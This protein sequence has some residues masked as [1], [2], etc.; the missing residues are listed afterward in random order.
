M[1][2]MTPAKA[3]ITSEELGANWELECLF[4]P[5]QFTFAKAVNWTKRENKGRNIPVV[6]FSGGQPASLTMSLFFDVYEP[7]RTKSGATVTDVRKFTNELEKLTLIDTDNP[8]VKNKVTGQARPPYCMFEWG[9]QYKF[10]AV[11]TSLTVRYTLFRTNGEPVRAEAD[12][13]F[14]QIADDNDQPKQN[15]TSHSETGYRRRAV[16]Q[17]DTIAGIAY[18]EF[19][20]SN[21]WRVIAD[22]NNLEDP[23]DLRPGQ[24]LAIPPR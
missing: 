11:V 7:F 10:K 23:T 19:G 13:T 18:Q 3:K 14:Q 6:D 4:N 12:I 20:D 17:G 21:R 5:E 2:T 9:P 1:P 24:F 8:Q 16:Q 15:P 22:L